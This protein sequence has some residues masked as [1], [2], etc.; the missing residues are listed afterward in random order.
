MSKK[1]RVSVKEVS[2]MKPDDGDRYMWIEFLKKYELHPAGTGKVGITSSRHIWFDL[3]AKL[4]L[5]CFEKS[6]KQ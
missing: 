2:T 1:T 6:R 5:F 4:F 3:A